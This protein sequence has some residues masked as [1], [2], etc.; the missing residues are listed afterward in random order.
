MLF[1]SPRVAVDSLGPVLTFQYD[2]RDGYPS[3]SWQS[4]RPLPFLL[5]RVFFFLAVFSEV[6]STVI[7]L[8]F[9]ALVTDQCLLFFFGTLTS[10]FFPDLLNFPPDAGANLHLARSGLIFRK[11]P[12]PTVFVFFVWETCSSP[13]HIFSPA[14]P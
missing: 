2:N 14:P 9:D 11:G 10:E 13:F 4:T 5:C 7:S 8:G 3:T 12:N 1:F 6:F